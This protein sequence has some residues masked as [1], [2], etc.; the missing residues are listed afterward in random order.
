M[1]MKKPGIGTYE[2]FAERFACASESA[3]KEQYLIPYFISGHPGST[4][5]DMISLAQYLKERGMR[6]RQVQDFIPTPMSMATCMH[7]TGID[8]LT[9]TEVRTVTDLREK[10]LHKALLLYWDEAQHDLTREALEKAG[11]RD[12]IGNGPRALV[13][14]APRRPQRPTREVPHRSRNPREAPRGRR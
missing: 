11:R 7:V 1:K 8:P 4:L 6:P 2:K 10:K 13:P 14:F 5:A 3:G 12:L 9:M